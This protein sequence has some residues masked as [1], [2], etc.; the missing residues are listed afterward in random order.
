LS[1]F[2]LCLLLKIFVCVTDTINICDST[3]GISESDA[4]RVT[5]LA[6]WMWGT[7]YQDDVLNRLA[8]GRF[9]RE[10]LDVIHPAV[11]DLP[12]PAPSS[13]FA[14]LSHKKHNDVPVEQ[15]SHAKMMIFSGHDS[16]LVPVLCALGI[17][18][19]TVHTAFPV[20]STVPIMSSRVVNNMFLYFYLTYCCRRLAAIRILSHNRGCS[21]TW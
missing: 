18:D 21:D 7:M 12:T 14:F 13:P 1:Y 17:Y 9:L 10:L 19:G 5:D 4:D 8:I 3:V 6:G 11:H 2:Q 16:T 20:S 15:T